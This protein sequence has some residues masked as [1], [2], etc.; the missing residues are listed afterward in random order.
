MEKT[1]LQ[2][3][4]KSKGLLISLVKIIIH[5]LIELFQINYLYFYKDKNIVN[6][7]RKIKKENQLLLDYDEAY[8]LYV[9]VKSVNK[10]KGDIAEVGV[11]RGGSAK[12]ICEAK[13]NK[14][15]H[16]FDTFKGL[17]EPDKLFDRFYKARQFI[18]SL[19]FVKKYLNSY[20]GVYFHKGI[21]PKSAKSMKNINFSFVH[22]DVDLYQSTLD[23]LMFFYPRLSDGGI[24]ISHDY[25]QALGVKKAFDDFFADKLE[26]IIE[27]PNRQCLVTKL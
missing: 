9:T 5:F 20:K 11:Y 27:L 21:F 13:R 1:K 15:I 6:I 7:I 23:S 10:I 19:E 16:L 8:F 2:K 17:P 26:I 22:L 12:L 25:T 24:I 3:L 18:S 14:V 4:F